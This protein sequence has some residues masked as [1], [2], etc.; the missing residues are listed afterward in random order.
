MSEQL[1]LTAA[2]PNPEDVDRLVQRFQIPFDDKVP[3]LNEP[4]A[5]LLHVANR[6]GWLRRGN[7]ERFYLR[8]IVYVPFS[9][10]TAVSSA[11]YFGMH[12]ENRWNGTIFVAPLGWNV[13]AW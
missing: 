6:L 2:G 4:L 11:R 3:D 7:R 10:K 5:L 1:R 9:K 12:G 8:V 13:R